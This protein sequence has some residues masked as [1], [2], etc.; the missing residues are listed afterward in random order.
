MNLGG[1][2]LTALT[3]RH[4]PAGERPSGQLSNPE[5]GPGLT[6]QAPELSTLCTLLYQTAHRPHSLQFF[7]P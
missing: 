1:P 7:N 6:P 3:L 4:K 2:Q 5:A